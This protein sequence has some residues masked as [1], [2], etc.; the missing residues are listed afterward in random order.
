MAGFAVVSWREKEKKAARISLML[1]LLGIVLFLIPLLSLQIKIV[2]IWTMA[3]S[4]ICLLTLFLW[5]GKKIP[6]TF[7]VPTIRFDERDIPLARWRLAKGTAEYETYYSMRPENLAV[8]D[9]TRSKPGLYS[10]DSLFADP[11]LCQAANGSFEL[12]EYMRLAVDGEIAGKQY[13]LSTD[14]MT[15]YIKNL[16]KYYGAL[17]V[18]ITL[19]QPYHIYSHTG[20]SPDGYGLPIE[21]THKFAIALSVE[22]NYE[23]VGPNPTTPGSLETAK[24]Y[25]EVGRAA[26]QLANAIR[27][28][29]Y[30]ARAHVEGNYHVICPLVAQ[31]A[32]LGEIG[33]M[34]VIMTPKHGPRVRLA[35]VTT[36]LALNIDERPD[37][38]AILDFCTICKKCA[39]N[40]PSQSIPF[41][42]RIELDDALRWK[43][44]G[45]GCLR[46][47]NTAGTD[48]GRC[49]SVCPYAHENNI[50]HNIIRWGIS[51]SYLFR[52]AANKMDDVL[53]G[54]KPALRE[55]PEWI[56]D[57]SSD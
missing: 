19:L 28:M 37:G 7:Q 1:A 42:D 46:Y 36:E 34:G 53:Y 54:K 25:V 55:T 2:L 57:A 35:V 23:M 51:H 20:R 32:G 30:P 22:M 8:D 47:W 27:L 24:Q 49:L 43:I 40:C 56:K 21:N 45:D 14:K 4:S 16:G 3:I 39:E 17:D 6:G 50:Y 38:S 44:D 15:A 13:T 11:F 29:G 48:C 41:D 18:G 52:R 26:V 5:P 31:D 10:P 33:R 9:L 12:A